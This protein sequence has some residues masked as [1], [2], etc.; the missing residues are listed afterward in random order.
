ML[1]NI[2][3]GDKTWVRFDKPESIQPDGCHQENSSV[4]SQ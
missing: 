3:M 1:T 2:V 4:Q